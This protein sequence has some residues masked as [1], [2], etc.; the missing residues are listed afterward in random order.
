MERIKQIWSQLE[1]KKVTIPGLVKIR[2]SESNE[3]DVFLGIKAPELNRMLIIRTPFNL[4]KEFDFKYEFRGVRFEKIYD[5]D[6]SGFLLLNLIL[7]D[8]LLRDIYD[9]LVYDVI[10]SIIQESDIKAILKI[11]TNRLTKWQ[12]LFERYKQQGLTDEEQRGLYGELF[13]LR[14]MLK[15]NRDYKTVITSWIGPENQVRDFQFG[16]WSIEVKTTHG[17][18]HQKVFIS[19]ERQL[20]ITNVDD[21][22]LYHISLD[23]RQQT[24]E[25]LNDIVEELYLILESDLE[26]LNLFRN[27]ITEAGFFNHH[28]NLYEGIGYFIRQDLFYKVGGNFPRIEEGEIR[29]GVGDVSYSIIISQCDQYKLSEQDVFT[30][31]KL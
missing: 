31:I 24:G 27:K 18:N 9:T 19:S 12:N 3:C 7:V 13:L 11:Y 14:K 1:S 29:D 17:N 15:N 22:I 23:V 2:Y 6:D 25:T 10:S 8:N 16:N 4:G 20:D 21:L 30:V 28:R 26:S 5:P